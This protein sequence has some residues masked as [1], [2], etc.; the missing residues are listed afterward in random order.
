MNVYHSGSQGGL[1]RV[2]FRGHAASSAHQATAVPHNGRGPFSWLEVLL[3]SP[4]QGRTAMPGV[5]SSQNRGVRAAGCAGCKWTG[6][7]SDWQVL[8]CQAVCWGILQCR[9]PLQQSCSHAHAFP[10]EGRACRERGGLDNEC[11][12]LGGLQL[13]CQWIRFVGSCCMCGRYGGSWQG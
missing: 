6:Q 7:A 11:S 9:C 5:G 13:S 2:H 3:G 1:C 12:R 10:G 4:L 8:C